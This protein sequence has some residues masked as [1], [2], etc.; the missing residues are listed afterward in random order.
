MAVLQ[1]TPEYIA[2]KQPFIM[3]VVSVGQELRQSTVE[4]ACLCSTVSGAH[5]EDSKAGIRKH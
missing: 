2:V 4:T 1:S 5:L 3:S